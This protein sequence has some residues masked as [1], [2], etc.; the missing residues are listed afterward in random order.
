M[1]T[2]ESLYLRDNAYS[3]AKSLLGSITAKLNISKHCIADKELLI[4]ILDSKDVKTEL[5]L[6]ATTY[7]Q[8]EVTNKFLQIFVPIFRLGVRVGA[9]YEI[10]DCKKD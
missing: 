6:L 4:K 1:K 2:P 7:C 8:H 10:E 9:L 5:E 3:Q